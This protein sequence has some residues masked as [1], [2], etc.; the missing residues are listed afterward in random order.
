MLAP[1]DWQRSSS[2]RAKTQLL[3]C[4]SK[5]LCLHHPFA[6]LFL[7]L[8][9]SH[10]T[11]ARLLIC[12]A[13]NFEQLWFSPSCD[14]NIPAPNATQ[15]EDVL[16]VMQSFAVN[17]YLVLEELLNVSAGLIYNKKTCQQL[18]T[19]LYFLMFTKR[20]KA[21]KSPTNFFHFKP[22]TSWSLY[23]WN[24]LFS[25][26]YPLHEMHQEDWMRLLGNRP[27]DLRGPGLL[28]VPRRTWIHWTM[29]FCS[30]IW[31][32]SNLRNH[33]EDFM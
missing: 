9:V 30:N 20:T 26:L 21:L 24:Y 1:E 28:V 17:A 14:A 3:H 23:E 32:G 10:S 33:G 27:N 22:I 15:A 13:A 31:C 5:Q 16:D 29:V 2:T 8:M 25:S 12:I 4:M 18:L 11:L 19:S 7:L 6:S